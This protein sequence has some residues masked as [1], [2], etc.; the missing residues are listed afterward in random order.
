[1][2]QGVERSSIDTTAP[3]I[4]RQRAAGLIDVPLA[5][6]APKCEFSPLNPLPLN[7]VYVNPVDLTLLTGNVRF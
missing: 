7:K 6:E 5:P 3:R 1:M 2:I 4:G